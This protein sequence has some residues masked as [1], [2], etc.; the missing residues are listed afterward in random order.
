MTKRPYHC[1]HCHEA[2]H[3]ARRCPDNP[4]RPALAPTKSRLAVEYMREHGTTLSDVARRFGITAQ[5]VSR[6]WIRQ[7]HGS[8]PSRKTQAQK[9][10]AILERLRAGIAATEIA[11]ELG[12]S[13]QHVRR[14]AKRRREGRAS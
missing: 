2:G 13:E 5:A 9:R 3:S 12:V 4:E 14:I 10:G 11:E 1:S 8:T 7:G 6:E